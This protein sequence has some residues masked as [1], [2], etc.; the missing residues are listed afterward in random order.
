MANQQVNAQIHELTILFQA[1]RLQEARALGRQM[2]SAAPNNAQALV[3]LGA[4]HGGL[5]EFKEAESC[6]GSLCRLEPNYFQHFYYYGLSFVMQGRLKEAVAPFERMLQ[7]HPE[8]AEGHMQMGCLRRDLGQHD[9]AIMH[10]QRALRLSPALLDAA[11]FLANILIFRGQ[12]EAA[13]ELCNQVLAK[14]PK[15]PE[16]SASKALILE[17]QGHLDAAWECLAPVVAGNAVTPSTAII[18]AKLAPKYGSTHLAIVLLN[19]V[20]SRQSWAP[21]QR[22]EMYFALGELNDKVGNYDSAF[23]H[24]R[25]ANSLYPHVFDI[26]AMRGKTDKIIEVFAGRDLPTARSSSRELPTPIFI[27]GMPRSGTSLVEQILGRHPDVAAGGELGVM[28]EVER[29][30]ASIVGDQENYPECLSDASPAEMSALA[31]YYLDAITEIA[32]GAR[33]V[34]DKLPVNYERLG[35]IEK[36]F[37]SAR[38]VHTTRHPL[39][40]CLSCYFQNFGNTQTYS[41]D[42]RVLAEVYRIYAKLMA[43]WHKT[44]SIRIL[45]ISYEVLVSDPEATVRTLL[46]FCNLSWDPRCLEFYKS[47]RY[48]NTASYDQVRQPIYRSSVGR[49]KHYESHIRELIEALS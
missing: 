43:H 45:D 32:K 47:T 15:H 9:L 30:A 36:L 12:M 37:P 22:Q 13:L 40:T 4:I 14:V 11:V 28:E 31:D 42:L 33:F 7:L 39:D 29:R 8:S 26:I 38:I 3:L 21:S 5:G 2:L 27:V 16:A 48:V 19:T 24:Y 18:Y 35:L 20:L 17:K 6:Y 41:S 49:W 10:L 46:E 44:L 34:T 1:N 23:S 25:S